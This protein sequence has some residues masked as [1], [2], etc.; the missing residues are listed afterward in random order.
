[1]TTQPVAKMFHDGNVHELRQLTKADFD[2]WPVIL[3]ESSDWFL[4]YFQQ[5]RNFHLP[6]REAFRGKPFHV[7]SSLMLDP[8]A[9]ELRTNVSRYLKD[10]KFDTKHVIGIHIRT[11]KFKP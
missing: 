2:S 7:I 3:F 9:P 5:N 4:P 10:N 11:K 8:I 1:M 6:I